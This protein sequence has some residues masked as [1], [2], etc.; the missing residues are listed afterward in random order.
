MNNRTSMT[1]RHQPGT[2]SDA[3]TLIE[4][5]V[6]I[7]II[8]ILAGLLLPALARAKSKAKDIQCVSNLKQMSLAYVMYVTDFNRSFDYTDNNNLWMAT[9]LAYH[10]QVDAIRACPV[11]T[12]SSTRIDPDAL[13]TYGTADRMWKWAPYTNS[14][15]GSFAYNGWLYGGTYS[16]SDL[17]GTPPA[18]K[19]KGESSIL[20]PSNTPV[21]GDAMWIDGWPRE[22]EGPSKDLYNGNGSADMGRFTIA[23]HGGL[24]PQGAPRA[25]TSSVGLP[26]AVNIAFVDGHANSV[27]L[28]NLWMLDWHDG[29]TTPGTIPNPK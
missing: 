24:S 12:V 25:L 16:T 22:A 7:A 27:K 28:M 13:H 11:A 23:R 18:W 14:Y 10:S 17:L 19:Y 20:R 2:R 5:L 6:V 3:F 4:L 15:E 26:G 9:L 21:F 29:W 8:A 1:R